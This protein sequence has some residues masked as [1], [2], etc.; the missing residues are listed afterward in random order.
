MKDAALNVQ[1]P[2]LG[3][4]LGALAQNAPKKF[5]ADV[6]VPFVRPQPLHKLHNRVLQKQVRIVRRQKFV[7]KTGKKKNE[8]PKKLLKLRKQNVEPPLKA[9]KA[10]KARR[11]VVQ[12][13]HNARPLY[14]A[15]QRPLLELLKPQRK[16]VEREPFPLARPLPLHFR[17]PKV[18]QVR[19]VRLHFKKEIKSE[20]VLLP[21]RQMG[22]ERMRVVQ[23]YN[24]HKL[25]QQHHRPLQKPRT[26]L[27]KQN[28][29]QQFV[30]PPQQ[31]LQRLLHPHRRR[32]LP[33]FFAG[34]KLG[35]K[36]EPVP[37]L[38]VVGL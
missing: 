23:L 10:R 1:Q 5:A 9:G 32:H 13:V 30:L 29:L 33:K 2:A 8:P 7:Y 37:L 36:V 27:H 21:K 18:V 3:P 31:V 38:A 19:V 35:S 6:R 4:Q 14:V 12:L 16:V 28:V 15:K 26:L 22:Y 20:P 24:P 17:L 11:R 34:P 25:V